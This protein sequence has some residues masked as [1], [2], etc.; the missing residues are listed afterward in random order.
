MNKQREDFYT[1]VVVLAF[2]T[3]ANPAKIEDSDDKALYYRAPYTSAKGVKPFLAPS[4]PSTSPLPDSTIAKQKVIDITS[5][6]QPD[7]T[8]DWRVPDGAWTIM[9]FGVRNNGANTRPAPQAGYGFECDKFSTTALDAHLANYADKL[10]KKVGDRKPGAGWTMMHIDSWEMGAQNWTPKFRQEFKHRRGYDPQPYYPAYTGQIVQNTEITE[11]FLWDLRQTAQELVIENHA[12]HLKQFAHKNGLGLSI[13][14]YDMNPTADLSLGAVA[15][16]PMGEFWANTFNSAFSCIEAASIAHTM[17]RPIV[18]A[19]SFTSIEPFILYPANLKN[20]AD[21]AFGSG[22]NRIFFHTFQHQPLGDD[23]VPGMTFGPYGVNWQRNQTWWPMVDEFHR[24]LTRCS[25]LLRQG[26]TVAD[27]LYLTPEGAPQVFRAPSDATVGD[28]PYLSDRRGYNFDGCPPDTLISRAE[29]SNDRIAFPGGTSYR[30]L[31]LPAME[32]MTPALLA[33]I[34][35]LV[36]QGATVIGAP[37]RRS[38]SLSGYPG[39][40]LK[41][42]SMAKTLWGEASAPAVRTDRPFGKGHLFW[43]GD[44]SM[45]P[46]SPTTELYPS[47][48]AAA[49][50]LHALKLPE[51][52]ASGGPIRYTHR[53][54]DENDIYFIANRSDKEVETECRFR[55]PSGMPELWNPVTGKTQPLPLFARKDGLASVPLKFA[56]HQS[57]FIIFSDETKGLRPSEPIAQS[58]FP[59]TKSLGTLEGPWDVS[60]QSGRGA[61]DRIAF[62]KLEDWITCSEPGIRYFSG[63]A[64]YRKSFDLP[65]YRSI[66]ISKNPIY[67]DLGVVK[68]ICRVRAQWPEPRRRLDSPLA[69]GH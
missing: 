32:T 16:V 39:C 25:H 31:V 52:F 50:L 18:G 2:P 10:L 35:L 29:V 22:I 66:S 48:E 61:P 62:D 51:D 58:N 23:I 20:Q 30:L 68:D 46:A 24:Y 41:V 56:A 8:L 26:V 4:T 33:K 53:Q 67:L 6:L 12:G 47:Y 63:I 55:V 54:A 65:S 17:G 7:G 42:N 60:F 69:C 14:P 64:I 43:G 27:I 13:E 11:R 36:K 44:L 37:P 59:A 34:T 19:E 49:S 28:E 15:D 45:P 38:P 57:F 21:W 3:P 9:R 40:D 5:H 1:D